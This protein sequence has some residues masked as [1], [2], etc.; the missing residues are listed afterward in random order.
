MTIEM[1]VASA[2]IAFV[3]LIGAAIWH[4]FD[5]NRDFFIPVDEVE[6][7]EGAPLRVAGA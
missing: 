1:K 5:T 3:A 7:T 2:A 4:T 6:R